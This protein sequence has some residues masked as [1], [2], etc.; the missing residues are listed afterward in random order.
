MSQKVAA[1]VIAIAVAI[2]VTGCGLGAG[3]GTS[4]VSLTVTDNFGTTVVGSVT[5]AHVPGSE[6]V[7]RMLERSFRV[8]TR[9]G[10][11]FVE[12]IDGASGSASRRDW[13]YYVNGIQ[14]SL[15]AAGTS[16]HRGDRIWWDLHDWS[17]TDSI[18][19]VVG[20]FPEPFIHGSGGR[21]YPTVLECASDTQA[22]CQRVTSELNAIGVKAAAQAPGAGGAGADSLAVVVGTWHDVQSEFAANL[23]E[24]G[25]GSSGIYARFAGPAGSAL[26][27]LDPRGQVVRTLGAGAGLIAATAYSSSAPVWLITGTDAAGVSAAAAALTPARLRDHFALAVQGQTDLPVPQRAAT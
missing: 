4:G 22:A 3:K 14:A 25:P 9:Y 21:R 11:G 24:H 19:A 26:Q 20:S 12:S 23:I 10:G 27:L 17:A 7:M 1:A 8:R 6:T 16:V 15:G 2:A 5:D 13:F 18:P